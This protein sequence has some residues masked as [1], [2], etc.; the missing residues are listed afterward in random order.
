MIRRVSKRM[1][2]RNV[3]KESMH[4]FSLSFWLWTDDEAAELGPQTIEDLDELETFYSNTKQN[5]MRT[6]RSRILEG[7]TANKLQVKKDTRPRK[8]NVARNKEIKQF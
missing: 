6:H 8:W 3:Y 5:I 1:V 2:N 7:R 4:I